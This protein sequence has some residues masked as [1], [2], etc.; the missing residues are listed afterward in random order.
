M[1][2]KI[3][4]LKKIH[5]KSFGYDFATTCFPRLEITMI[6]SPRVLLPGCPHHQPQAT[7]LETGV[8]RLAGQPSNK[9]QRGKDN[10]F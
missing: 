8:C 6:E 10:E 2:P 9:L 3:I 5:L 4:E 7:R 1:L